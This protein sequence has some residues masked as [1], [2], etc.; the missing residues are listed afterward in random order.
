MSGV[1]QSEEVQILWSQMK[2]LDP[3]KVF[4]EVQ[5]KCGFRG[6]NTG[7]QQ[8]DEQRPTLPVLDVV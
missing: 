6:F 4:A 8:N 2:S 5:S 3:C 7:L 1:V